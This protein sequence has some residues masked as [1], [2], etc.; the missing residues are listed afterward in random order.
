MIRREFFDLPC[1][2][3]ALDHEW[4]ETPSTVEDHA[5]SVVNAICLLH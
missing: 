3:K 1:A 4:F 5:H 2:L